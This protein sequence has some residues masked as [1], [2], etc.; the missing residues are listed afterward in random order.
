MFVKKASASFMAGLSG[1][2]P[3]RG[4]LETPMIPFHHS[5]ILTKGLYSFPAKI[6]PENSQRSNLC[7]LQ[8]LD[9][10]FILY[11]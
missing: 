11:R 5:P 2:E 9:L 6:L 3:E 4:V 7:G 8:R 10:C 1:F